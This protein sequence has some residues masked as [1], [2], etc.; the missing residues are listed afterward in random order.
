[1]RAPYKKGVVRSRFEEGI[2]HT[3]WG[4][5]LKDTENRVASNL[6]IAEDKPQLGTAKT[7]HQGFFLGFCDVAKVAIVENTLAK[8]G[9]MLHMKVGNKH[10]PSI[11]AA[12][13]SNFS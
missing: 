8:F 6:C 4:P 10:N 1:M 11:F 13:Q 2:F 5:S 7:S 12:T 3:V 9:Y